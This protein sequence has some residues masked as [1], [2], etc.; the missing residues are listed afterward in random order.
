MKRRRRGSR[1][2]SSEG[3]SVLGNLLT[4]VFGLVLAVG[5]AEVAARVMFPRW[6]EFDSSRFITTAKVPGWPDVAIGRPGFNGWFSQ[7]NGDFRSQFRINSFGLRNDE[8][9]TAAA[10]R[11]WAV[12]DSFTFGWGVDRDQIMGAVAAKTLGMNWYDVASPGTDVCGYRTLIARMPAE[13][14]PKAVV[15]GLTIENDVM[16]YDCMGRKD[17]PPPAETGGGGLRPPPLIFFK[18]GLTQVSALYNF[19]AVAVKRVTS[20]QTLLIELKLIDA[21]NQG[22]RMFAEDRMEAVLASTA[23]EMGRLRDMLP[24]GTPLVVVVIPARQDLMEDDSFYRRQREDMVRLLGE[25][26]IIAID[27]MPLFQPHGVGAIHFP[28]DGHW[29]AL[30]HRLAG[31]A[32]AARLAEMGLNQ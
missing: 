16:D 11:L 6:D 4:I 24:A 22:K 31:E 5:L 15:V 29:S 7:N 28:H 17:A 25:R 13:A 30:G 20:L 19:V 12:G 27:P 9:E 14:R 1:G 23:D 18:H 26:D 21:P 3:G 32:V 10:G 8:P 2:Y